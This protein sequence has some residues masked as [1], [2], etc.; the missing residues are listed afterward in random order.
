MRGSEGGGYRRDRL[1][2]LDQRVEVAD[3]AIRIMGSKTKLLRTPIVDQ[4]RQSA[5]PDVPGSGLKWAGG[6]RIN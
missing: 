6:I 5:A 4:M 1:R 3:D 2:V